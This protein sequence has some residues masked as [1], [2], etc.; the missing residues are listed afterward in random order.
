MGRRGTAPYYVGSTG[1][2]EKVSG[3]FGVGVRHE[4]KVEVHGWQVC[5]VQVS[6]KAVFVLDNEGI[7]FDYGFEL[8]RFSEAKDFSQPTFLI[9]GDDLFFGGPIPRKMNRSRFHF[10][11]V[12]LRSLPLG[13]LHINIGP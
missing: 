3:E 2:E 5:S 7:A 13:E 6:S 11:H 10:L 1:V 8:L 9:L 12:F 4:D